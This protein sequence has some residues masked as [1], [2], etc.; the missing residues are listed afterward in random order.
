MRLRDKVAVVTGAS[1]GLG[2]GMCRAFAAEG[3][4]CLVAYHRDRE[5]AEE[6]AEAVREAGRRAEVLQV[7]VSSEEAVVEMVRK[8]LEVFGRLDIAV[9]NSGIGIRVPFI[10]TTSKQFDKVLA[11]NLRGTYLTMRHAAEPMAEAGGGKLITIASI[12]GIGGAHLFSLYAATKAGIIGLTKG[13]AF[14]LADQNIQVNCIA[15]GAV[16]V[17]REGE[18]DHDSPLA[19]AWYAQMPA[20]RMG[21]PSEIGAGA[22]YLASTDSDWITGQVLAIDGG[23]TAGMAIPSMKDFLPE[24]LGVD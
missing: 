17:P 1:G 4:D 7:D 8:T 12:H 21:R 22:V 6:T 20:N 14:D 3:A 24:Y 13:A 16:P 2:G 19:R 18:I 9:A 15:P 23:A 10:K 11:V 5:A